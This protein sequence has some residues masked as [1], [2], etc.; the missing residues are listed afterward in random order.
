M[1][2]EADP[3]HDRAWLIDW[4][5]PIL[6]AV[7]T[8]PACWILRFRA[9]GGHTA[10]QAERQ[11]ARLPAFADADPDHVDA[12]ARANVTMWDEIAQQNSLSWAKT[13]AR[14]ATDWAAYRRARRNEKGSPHAECVRRPVALTARLSAEFRACRGLV[15]GGGTDRRA[16]HV[17]AGEPVIGADA[18]RVTQVVRRCSSHSALASPATATVSWKPPAR[19]WL[20][21]KRLAGR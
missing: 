4:A 6:G 7:W 20:G 10:Q 17:V 21:Q 5:W 9:V 19:N 16:G 2:S 12:F 1:S 8:D 14:A 11:A 13:M 15:E 18:R 3:V